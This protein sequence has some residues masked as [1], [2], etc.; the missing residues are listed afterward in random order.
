MNKKIIIREFNFTLKQF[1]FSL[2]FH[3]KQLGTNLQT[4]QHGVCN[5]Y[6]YIQTPKSFVHENLLFFF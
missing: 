4:W 6:I 5:I 2:K 1:R 3:F